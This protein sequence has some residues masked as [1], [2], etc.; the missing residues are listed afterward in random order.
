MHQSSVGSYSGTIDTAGAS[1]GA[2]GDTT[3]H[4]SRGWYSGT[5][6]SDQWV[7]CQW[8]MDEYGRELVELKAW[9][10]K[11]G[12]IVWLPILILAPL[13]LLIL[14]KLEVKGF[15]ATGM[16]TGAILI[17]GLFCGLLIGAIA[18]WIAKKFAP[19]PSRYRFRSYRKY[20]INHDC[21]YCQK[22]VSDSDLGGSRKIPELKEVRAICK[23]CWQANKSK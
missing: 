1:Y 6:H 14:T 22:E 16:K 19:K 9:K 21:H 3:I 7:Q 12:L 20:V 2:G 10:W 17:I 18:W 15:K 5:S 4:G 11:W 23:N 13:I 8:C